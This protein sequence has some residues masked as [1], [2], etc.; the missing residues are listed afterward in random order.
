MEREGWQGP[1]TCQT[2][3]H[4]L[5]VKTELFKS[6]SFVILKTGVTFALPRAF[7]SGHPVPWGPVRPILPRVP[8]RS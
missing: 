5:Q 1:E 3:F 7:P 8:A 2:P 6:F 4:C